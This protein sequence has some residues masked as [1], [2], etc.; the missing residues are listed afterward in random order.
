MPRIRRM[1]TDKAG[2]HY[3]LEEMTDSHLCNVVKLLY[4]IARTNMREDHT[5]TADEV[6]NTTWEEYIEDT[7]GE[8]HKDVE[9]WAMLVAVFK[10][11]DLEWPLEQRKKTPRKTTK[12]YRKRNP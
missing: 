1:W 9:L 3:T 6:M 12:F 7:L 11:R 10:S 4:N 5:L 2:N 8:F